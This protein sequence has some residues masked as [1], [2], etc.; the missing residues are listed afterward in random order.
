MWAT[1]LKRAYSTPYIETLHVGR[2]FPFF[3]FL[4]L[5][6]L[7][8]FRDH[9]GDILA[10]CLCDYLCDVHSLEDCHFIYL[11]CISVQRPASS[12]QRPAQTRP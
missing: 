6:R 2:F 11:A 12:V 4:A 5:G 8:L 10:N 7:P 3:P 1:F 9:V